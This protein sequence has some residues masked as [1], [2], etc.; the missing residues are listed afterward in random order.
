M[1]YLEHRMDIISSSSNKSIRWSQALFTALPPVPSA[2]WIIS[3][4]SSEAD[5]F[6]FWTALSV[7]L[8]LS[9]KQTFHQPP[10]FH[11][12]RYTVHYQISY[13]GAFYAKEFWLHVWWRSSPH[14]CLCVPASSTCEIGQ[15]AEG[16]ER[17]YFR[18]WWCRTAKMLY[19]SSTQTLLY[20][21][22]IYFQIVSAVLCL[23]FSRTRRPLNP[24]PSVS[25]TGTFI[26]YNAY[27]ESWTSRYGGF[28]SGSKHSCY[29]IVTNYF[30]IVWTKWTK[31]KVQVAQRHGV[32]IEHRFVLLVV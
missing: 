5:T 30:A 31:H 12:D 24:R 17:T 16:V 21:P 14:I 2:A 25:L 18:Y 26:G 11:G 7:A 6:H 27:T 13:I 3:R 9:L 28:L 23:K 22:K 4:W 15:P 20:R 10:F 19:T 8:L 29:I 32:Y 1:K